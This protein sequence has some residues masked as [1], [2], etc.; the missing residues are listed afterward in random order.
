MSETYGRRLCVVATSA[1]VLV[2]PLATACGGGDESAQPTT[3]TAPT[4]APAPEFVSATE[5]GSTTLPLTPRFS[6][7]EPTYPTGPQHAPAP[8][9]KHFTH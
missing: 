3:P 4:T 2:G 1:A 6:P 7:S 5:A 8:G 9:M